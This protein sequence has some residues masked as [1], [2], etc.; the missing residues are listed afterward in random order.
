MDY[1]EVVMLQCRP[2]CMYREGEA[3]MLTLQQF[4]EHDKAGT[5][6]QMMCTG[7]P[8]S[9]SYE[10]VLKR[11][12]K[13]N[14]EKEKAAVAPL[15]G[16]VIPPY[17]TYAEYKQTL[18]TEIKREVEGYVRIGYLLKLARDTNILAESGYANLYDFAQAEYN[19][20]K[21]RVSR[22][23]AINDRFAENGYSLELKDEYKGYGVAKLS[24]M[25]TLPD[26]INEELTPTLSKAEIQTLRDEVAEEERTTPLEHMIEG[27][28]D[29]TASA[30]DMLSKAI[31]Q[32]GESEPEMYVEI[33]KLLNSETSQPEGIK[34]IMAPSE[35]KIYSIRIRGVGRVMLCVKDYEE[36]VAIVN[37]R[38]GEKETRSWN[39]VMAVWKGMLRG[40]EPKESWENIYGL[41]FPITQSEPVAQVQPKKEVK[42][43]KVNEKKKPE[44]KMLHDINKDIPAPNP[45]PE[46]PETE[47]MPEPV[48][49]QQL[50]GQK[51]IS[52][53]PEYMPPKG[54]ITRKAYDEQKK[55]YVQSFE[56]NIGC[57]EENADEKQWELAKQ[58]LKDAMHY[59]DLLIKLDAM[60]VEDE[61]ADEA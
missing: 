39:D 41:K 47:P 40:D 3:C 49:E 31:L 54:K 43:Q 20:D 57:A 5:T 59:L 14:A 24:L 17:A 33:H 7:H 23:M 34:R 60:E 32:L 58:D 46:E 28:T 4:I 25:L 48:T 19:L 37:E 30:E 52:D 21:S 10:S 9:Y 44:Q 11:L 36:N 51:D 29:T 12:T 53:Y 56:N 38:T 42:V 16:E 61:K 6:R 50:P 27:E 13:E 22:Y 15:Q 45:K 8:G 55:T 18:D 35:E 26:A 1:K 2:E